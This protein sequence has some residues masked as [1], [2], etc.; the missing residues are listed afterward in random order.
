MMCSSFHPPI[1]YCTRAFVIQIKTGHTEDDSFGSPAVFSK[2]PLLS[3][4]SSQK[5][6]P[7]RE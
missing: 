2:D 5:V 6:W 3:A 1:D 7:Y 4:P